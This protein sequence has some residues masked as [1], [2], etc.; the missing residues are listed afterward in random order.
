[1]KSQVIPQQK[2]MMIAKKN[3]F[4]WKASSKSVKLNLTL[5]GKMHKDYKK[6]K[7]NFNNK[8]LSN[9]KNIKSNSKQQKSNSM[10]PKT[11]HENTASKSLLS[12]K[13]SPKSLT[14]STRSSR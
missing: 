4:M 1:L 2:G 5:K 11:K 10:T 7:S 14:K 12:S 3:Y 9:S 6:L 13:A 8:R